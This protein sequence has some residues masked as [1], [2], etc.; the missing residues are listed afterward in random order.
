M[1]FGSVIVAE[2]LAGIL[3]SNNGSYNFPVIGNLSSKQFGMTNAELTE[4]HE[5]FGNFLLF[6]SVF[7]LLIKV[8]LTV[9]NV[10]R[11]HYKP[12]IDDCNFASFF[13]MIFLCLCWKKMFN[14]IFFPFFNFLRIHWQCGML[15]QN[16]GKT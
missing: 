6:L 10:P 4:F 2:F 5:Y 11:E 1:P 7:Y 15:L 12:G 3:I 8:Y 14:I 9:F 16:T 13:K